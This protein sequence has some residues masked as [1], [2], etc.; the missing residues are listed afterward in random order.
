MKILKGE[1]VCVKV[2]SK[3]KKKEKKTTSKLEG[4]SSCHHTSRVMPQHIAGR[5]GH[6]R[7][8]ERTG[9]TG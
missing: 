5:D 6:G 7:D 8:T 1:R 2:K 4:M 3:K 9:Q